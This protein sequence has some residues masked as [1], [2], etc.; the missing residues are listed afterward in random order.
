MPPWLLA[1]GS[2]VALVL[3]AVAGALAAARDASAAPRRSA[4]ARGPALVAAF[5]GGALLSASAAQH[6]LQLRWPLDLDDSKALVH[7]CVDGVPALEPGRVRFDVRFTVLEPAPSRGAVR[8]ARLLWQQPARAPRAAECWRLVVRLRAPRAAVN[9]G[10]VDAEKIWFRDGLHATGSVVPGS[11]NRHA[12][13]RAVSLDAIRERI[14]AMIRERVVDRDAAALFAALAVGVTG[15]MSAAQWR[16]F[17]ATGTTH[18]VAISG[19][20]VTM[21]AALAVA[22]ARRAWSRT[23]LRLRV[24]RDAFAASIGIMAASAYA[25]LAGLSVPTLRTLLMLAVWWVARRSGR[26]CGPLEVLSLALLAVLAVDPLAPLAAGF[27]LSFIAVAVLV[28]GDGRRGH[29]GRVREL[30]S[31]QWRVGVAMLPVTLAL[32]GRAAFAGTLANLAAVPVFTLVLVPLVLLGTLLLPVDSPA[33]RWPLEAAATVHALAWPALE[34]MADWPLATVSGPP[35]AW[36]F[37]VLATGVL[38]A[39]VPG[40]APVRL[41]GVLAGAAALA[42][43]ASD[44]GPGRFRAV[45]LDA[46]DGLAVLVRTRSQALAVGT[47]DVYGSR[48][49]LALQL[50]AP[51]LDATGAMS[52]RTLVLPDGAAEELEGGTRLVVAG[53][54]GGLVAG[55]SGRPAATTTPCPGVAHASLDGVLVSVF[56]LP[57]QGGSPR[58]RCAVRIAGRGGALLVLGR[59]PEPAPSPLPLAADVVVLRGPA[60]LRATASAWVAAI[61]PRALVVAGSRLDAGRRERLARL[62]GV[63]AARTFPLAKTGALRIEDSDAGGLRVRPVAAGVAPLWR[64]APVD[65][66]GAA[67]RYDSPSDSWWTALRCG[68]SCGPEAR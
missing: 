35:G 31:T 14:A 41:L 67:L 65:D 9:P 58:T 45:V 26:V 68:K 24:E 10:G 50:L 53:R 3:A 30:L 25:L 12:G 64:S 18:L 8:R 22:I 47:G 38:L 13:T 44:L 1:A 7:A 40:P 56:S 27:W 29:A 4:A 66:P 34:R 2:A 63:E 42:P 39:V 43:A 60:A 36:P 52:L 17:A 5:A 51:A 62:W 11:W 16:V 23:P 59:V 20:H 55:G 37:A 28:A 19:L 61:G 15:P 6:V 48:G 32:F 46:G 49:R 21:L 33:G 54:A 57:E